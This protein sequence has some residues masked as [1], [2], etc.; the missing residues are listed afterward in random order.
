M[1][2]SAEFQAELR[3]EGPGS[4]TYLTVPTDV[5]TGL[6]AAARIPVRAEVEGIDFRSSVMTGPGDSRYLVVNKEIRNKAGVTEG[7]TVRVRLRVD[8]APREVAVPDD[9]DERLSTN[10]EA[11]EFFAGLSYSRQKEYVAWVE[12]AKRPETRSRRVEQAVRRLAEHR[13]LK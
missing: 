9:L 6:G 4:W 1:A 7:D 5:A 10:P 12:D 11:Q 8:D 13:T 3:C 2:V